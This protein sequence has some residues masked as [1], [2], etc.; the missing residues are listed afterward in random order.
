VWQPSQLRIADCQALGYF[1]QMTTR[2]YPRQIRDKLQLSRLLEDLLYLLASEPMCTP[3][4]T[5]AFNT[6]IPISVFTRLTNLQHAPEDAA[7]V[8]LEDFYTVFSNVTVRYPTIKLWRLPDQ[9]VF[10]TW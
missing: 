7:N 4:A 5:L 9:T 2:L 1:L 8:Q 10:I 6:K 3:V